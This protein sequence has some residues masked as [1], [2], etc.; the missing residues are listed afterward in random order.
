M[1]FD[2]GAQSELTLDLNS[3][4]YSGFKDDTETTTK[5]LN[6]FYQRAPGESRYSFQDIVTA[7]TPAT[8]KPHFKSDYRK[9]RR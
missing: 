9:N 4:K 3:H 2:R 8:I 7:T 1:F 6:P 5:P